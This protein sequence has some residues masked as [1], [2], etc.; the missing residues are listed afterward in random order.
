MFSAAT[1]AARRAS[2]L[3]AMRGEGAK[4]IIFLPGNSA[5][6][7]NYINNAY[8]FRQDSTF[9]YYFGH[10]TADLNATL[11][12]DTGTIRLWADTQTMDD[13]IWSGPLPSPQAMA[14]RCGCECAP[15]PGKNA[16]VTWLRD[17]VRQNAPLHFLPPYQADT[18]RWLAHCTGLPETSLAEAASPALIR[19]VVAQRSIKTPDE[20]AEIESALGISCAMYAKAMELARPGLTESCVASAMNAAVALHNSHNSFTTICTIR[21]EVLHN[22]D[23]SHVMKQGDLLLIDS[24]AESGR[25]YA[26]DIT[27][28]L[29]VG[30]L[31]SSRQRD[32]YTLVLAMQQAAIDLAAPDVSYRDCHMAAAHC[33]ADG[34]RGM[35]LLRG[36]VDDIV[37]AGAHALFFPHGLGHLLGL[38]VHDME[39]L[40][41]DY[42]GYDAT[43][44]RSDQFGLHALRFAREL[45]PGHVLTVE[46]GC[47]FIPALMDRWQQ[48]GTCREFI[49]YEALSAFRDFGGI[50]IEDD[51][52]ITESGHRVLGPAIAKT[53]EGIEARMHAGS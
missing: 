3:A 14:E 48:Q 36:S 50:R 18:A 49:N 25:Y 46:P 6:P 9:L 22:H 27:R 12:L 15:S 40:G 21:G 41:E 53:P 10:N 34:L 28:T 47:Y 30:G 31:F 19:S 13:I 2:L 4:G 37:A 44:A 5:I 33:L 38:D 24:G 8:P 51:L 26:S 39:H 32:V 35:G 42:V 11:D 23:Y 29:P 43:H 20:V 45:R 1:L 52:L 16:L 17:A 7:R